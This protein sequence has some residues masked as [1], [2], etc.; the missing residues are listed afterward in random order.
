MEAPLQPQ[1]HPYWPAMLVSVVVCFVFG[2]VWYGPLFGKTWA[3]AMGFDIAKKPE[4][5]VMRRALLLQIF[6]ACLMV[7]VMANMVPVW[8][9]SVWGAGADQPDFVYGLLGGFFPWL[10]F[11]VPLQLSKI[12]WESKS[13]KVFAINAGHDFIQ[14][15]AVAMILSCWR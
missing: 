14:L 15:Q 10:G 6:G 7:F 9:A 2:G 1:I 5:A 3:V 11:Y 12:A 13:W 4:A 8:R